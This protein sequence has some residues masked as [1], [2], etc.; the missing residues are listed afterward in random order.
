M[1]IKWVEEKEYLGSMQEFLAAH[2]NAII[3]AV[4]DDNCEEV[5]DE[6]TNL[7]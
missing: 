1:K 3:M 7:A 6:L 4:E 2:P 5:K